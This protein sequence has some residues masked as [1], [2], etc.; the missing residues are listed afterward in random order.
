MSGALILSFWRKNYLNY[1]V[2]MLCS[3]AAFILTILEQGIGGMWWPLLTN[4]PLGIGYLVVFAMAAV[5]MGDFF[6]LHYTV[7]HL[8]SRTKNLGKTIPVRM[9]P[10]V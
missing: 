6:Y 5:M 9:S 8:P 3:F 4:L 10:Y 2:A 1:F 7:I